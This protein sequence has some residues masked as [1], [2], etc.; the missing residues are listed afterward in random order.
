[1]EFPAVGYRDVGTS[2]TLTN[3]GE[4]GNYWSSSSHNSTYA[5]RM[6]FS[7]SKLY[8]DN[9]NKQVGRSVRCVR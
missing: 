7:G 5:H 2:G 3:A 1:M 4:G 8:M 6:Y 9:Y